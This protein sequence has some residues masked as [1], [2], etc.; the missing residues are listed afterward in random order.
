MHSSGQFPYTSNIVI[1]G[2]MSFHGAMIANYLYK[3]NCYVTVIEDSINI[4]PVPIKWYRWT[5]LPVHKE[6]VDFSHN[7]NKL[8]KVL[9]T[10]G[11]S[12][13]LYVPTGIIDTH[14]P[15]RV[16]Q[17]GTSTMAHFQKLLSIASKVPSV[18]QIILLSTV[19]KGSDL[20]LLHKTRMSSLE[21][22][23]VFNFY[24][25]RKHDNMNFA[26]IKANGVFGPSKEG[27]ESN[28]N[29]WY[30][31]SIAS[32]V[33]DIASIFKPG[34]MIKDLTT[35]CEKNIT[36]GIM[37]TGQW[38]NEYKMSLMIRK[39]NVVAGAT[40]IY[41]S[42]AHWWGRLPTKDDHGYFRGFIVSA[43]KYI[44]N[45]HI[46][47]IHNVMSNYAISK[48]RVACPTCHFERY[49]PVNKRISHDQR[50]YMLYDYLLKNPD[51][52]NLVTTDIR[53]VLFTADPFRQMTEIGDYFYTS[54]DVPFYN[55]VGTFPW[56][57]K[58]IKKCLPKLKPEEIHEIF[59]LYGVFNS[60]AI[61][62]SRHVML[63]LLSRIVL[64]LDI[65]SLN[66][67]CDMATANVVYHLFNYDR[68]YAG[69]PFSGS[70]FIGIPGPQ[71]SATKHK[72]FSTFTVTNV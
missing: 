27:T 65:A 61:G 66:G 71:G 15:A 54:V 57:N 25:H 10:S 36:H 44:P 22:I 4:E 38:M 8:K 62:G 50:L 35:S 29:C 58:M 24:N 12:S 67:V 55:Y 20:S 26:L 48:Y 68:I 40:I 46:V 7:I 5:N 30:I 34:F 16:N 3:S 41:K 28:N 31:D 39:K 56:L 37:V 51:I 13:V 18:K 47:I 53:D 69:Y 72:I 6:L 17:V 49:S 32:L 1:V 70:Y 45:V 23:L 52:G 42:K 21:Q 19:D 14:D 59:N 63:T 11:A 60:G 64:L 2:G 9:K 33:F 43:L